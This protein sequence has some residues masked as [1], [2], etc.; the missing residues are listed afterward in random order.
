M[1]RSIR[2][3]IVGLSILGGIAGF[4]GS[5]LWLRGIKL[6]E[7]NWYV[8]AN[9]SDA[10]GLAERSPVTFRGILVGSV[11]K[12]TFSPQAV[13]ATLEIQK[14]DLRLP[15]PVFAKVVTSSLLGGD[16]QVS[17]ISLGKELP[18][19]SPLP[20][21]KTC[22]QSKVL[23]NAET[24]RGESLMS[25]STLTEELEKIIQQADKE[26]IVSSVVESSKQF[27]Q[28]QK[29][30]DDLIIQFKKEIYRAEPIITNLK[31][32]SSHINNILAAIDNPDTLE[33]LQRTASSTRSITKKIDNF[34]SDF[35]QILE[36]KELMY[37]IRSLTIGLG[38]L[39]NELYPEKI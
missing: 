20:Q 39:F 15:K 28:T 1:R 2:D 14:S 10:S 3:A 9:F 23:C 8:T 21:S 37:A 22:P 25:I 24:I 29:N 5:S 16:A 17:L 36:D 18:L 6:G 30:L 33:D 35:S 4:A 13:N 19:N 27:D 32:A 26:D 11:G 31:K 34:G 38:E 7:K 12:I